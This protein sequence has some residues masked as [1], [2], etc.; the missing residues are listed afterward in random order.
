MPV[1][2]LD[3]LKQLH[4]GGPD[5]T[6]QEMSPEDRQIADAQT[7]EQQAH[8]PV[9]MRAGRG[10]L[11][12]MVG[13]LKGALGVDD[14]SQGFSPNHLAQLGM[15]A[16]PMLPGGI[17]GRARGLIG[18][19]MTA[20]EAA[21]TVSRPFTMMPPSQA[22]AAGRSAA[23]VFNPGAAQSMQ[24]LHDQASSVFKGLEQAGTFSGDRSVGGYNKLA[25]GIYP[26][27]ET[28]GEVDPM[29]TPQ[30]GEGMFNMGRSAPAPVRDPVEAA[31][32]RLKL[33][34]GIPGQLNPA[35]S[36]LK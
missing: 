28:L 14:G 8:D 22:Q 24:R 27:Q 31:Y 7:E 16:L 26:V 13:G 12:G 4:L 11:D 32:Q 10:A 23:D 36:G 1:N 15:A 21:S 19:E 6:T 5:K 33:S 29:F 35:L 34:K 18:A 25:N 20:P 30:G 2:P 9:W 3:L 17:L